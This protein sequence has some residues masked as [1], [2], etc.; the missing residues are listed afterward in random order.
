MSDTS[1]SHRYSRDLSVGSL[2]CARFTDKSDQKL[3][4]FIAN[5]CH[6]HENN[7]GIHHKYKLQSRSTSQQLTRRHL[8]GRWQLM[9][10]LHDVDSN[11]Y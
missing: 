10:D 6:F 2:C 8:D 7:Y 11:V 1:L 4:L 9:Y 3:L 5:G